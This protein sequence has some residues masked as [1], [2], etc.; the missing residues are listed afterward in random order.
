MDLSLEGL[1]V[2]MLEIRLDS[3][4]SHEAPLNLGV[5][6]GFGVLGVSGFRGLGFR[7]LGVYRV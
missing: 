5:L 7:G 4:E 2:A 1:G 6:V 3:G